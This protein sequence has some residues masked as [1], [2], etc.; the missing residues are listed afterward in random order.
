M[1]VV[2]NLTEES[3]FSDRSGRLGLVEVGVEVGGSQ[4][5]PSAGFK[6]KPDP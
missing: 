2:E 1:V 6:A 4:S 3:S 5:P